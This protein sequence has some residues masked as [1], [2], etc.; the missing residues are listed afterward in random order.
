MIT[1]LIYVL[2]LLVVF[3]I[4]GYAIRM[5]PLP[6]PF[7]NIAYLILLLVFLLVLLSMLGVFPG[8]HPLVT[9]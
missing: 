1:L 2:I 8:T 3:A 4:I 5:I 9:L 7:A 6:P